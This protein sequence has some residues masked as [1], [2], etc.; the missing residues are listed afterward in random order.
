MCASV[1]SQTYFRFNF[2]LPLHYP[3]YAAKTESG[4][5]VCP[6]SEDVVGVW[7][8]L[9]GVTKMLMMTALAATYFRFNFRPRFP[10]VLYLPLAMAVQ[11]CTC[12]WLWRIVRRTK[13]TWPKSGPWAETCPGQRGDAQK[14]R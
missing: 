9:T 8:P 13:C 14:P 3:V 12:R 7:L 1:A 2:R 5:P 6:S 10:R 11:F 4:M